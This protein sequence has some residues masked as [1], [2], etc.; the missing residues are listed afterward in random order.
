MRSITEFPTHIL[1][2]GLKT[3]E[4][5]VAEGKTPEEIQ[6]AIGEAHKYEGDKLKHFVNAMDVAGQNTEKLRRVLV[7]ALNEGEKVPE[8]AV[9]VEETHYIPDFIVVK[10]A[11]ASTDGKPKRGGGKRESRGPKESPWGLSPEE[12]ANKNKKQVAAQETSAENK[13]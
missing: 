1:L 8:K 12:K 5:L 2:Q 3:K 6:T 13:Q 7:V 9:K 4:S 10:A 11:P